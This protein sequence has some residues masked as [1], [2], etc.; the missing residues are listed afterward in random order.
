MHNLITDIIVSYG[1]STV[2]IHTLNRLGVCSSADT[3]ARSIQ[4]RVNM[5]EHW[6]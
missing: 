3:L 4:Y 6:S 5:R 1:G 2:L